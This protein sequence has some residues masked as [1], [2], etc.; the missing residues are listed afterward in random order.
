M[1]LQADHCRSYR[2][3]VPNAPVPANLGKQALVLAAIT[4]QYTGA[5][6]Y[7]FA[8]KHDHT[9]SLNV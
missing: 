2:S 6:Q 7:E 5:R 1:P 3:A 9:C 8:Y 4:V